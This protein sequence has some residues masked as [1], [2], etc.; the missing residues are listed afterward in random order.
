MHRFRLG[1]QR[2]PLNKRMEKEHSRPFQLTVRSRG[3]EHIHCAVQPPP[4]RMVMSAK[5]G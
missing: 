5:E 2:G 4:S 3:V 1:V